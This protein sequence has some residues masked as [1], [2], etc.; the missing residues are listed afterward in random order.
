MVW[1]HL[2]WHALVALAAIEVGLVLEVVGNV[3]VARSLWA[4][5]YDDVEAA[6]VGPTG[7][8]YE[9]GHTVAGETSW[10]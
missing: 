3:R 5:S 6:A 9:L 8:G 7:A 2:P 10:S 1:K 4:T